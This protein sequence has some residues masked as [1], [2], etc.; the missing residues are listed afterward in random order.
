M[1][2]QLT[3]ADMQAKKATK[4]EIK[5]VGKA[6]VVFGFSSVALIFVTILLRNRNIGGRL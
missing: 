6:I 1:H 4:E 3:V 5:T 2:K